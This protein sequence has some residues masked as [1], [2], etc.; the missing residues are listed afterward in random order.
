M[1]AR[2]LEPSMSG[3]FSTSVT[4][5]RKRASVW[6][7]SPAPKK[8]EKRAKRA[9]LGGTGSGAHRSC[10]LEAAVEEEKAST[11]KMSSGRAAFLLLCG[12]PSACAL[13]SSAI[14][15]TE[16]GAQGSHEPAEPKAYR[17]GTEGMRSSDPHRCAGS[18][19]MAV[20]QEQPVL[21]QR[22]RD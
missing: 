2:S 5:P 12:L 6:S 7:D 20:R 18:Y 16:L 10:E 9:G 13:A 22:R 14:D 8:R 15:E 21:T 3:S 4:T 11:G 17:S 1:L 19:C